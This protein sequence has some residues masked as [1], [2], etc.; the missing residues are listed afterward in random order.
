MKGFLKNLGKLGAI[1]AL[2]LVA[3]GLWQYGKYPQVVQSANYPEGRYTAEV[4]ITPARRFPR[5][6]ETLFGNKNVNVWVRVR[7][8]DS[9]KPIWE[10]EI[11]R[12]LP[13]VDDAE[14]IRI[15]WEEGAVEFHIPEQPSVR[16]SFSGGASR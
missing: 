10:S 7:T 11:L 4:A 8:K 9:T 2:A 5:S 12:S 15:Q 6:L 16:W 13:S 1:L 3:C 14:E